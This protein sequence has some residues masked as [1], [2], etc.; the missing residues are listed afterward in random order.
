MLFGHIDNLKPEREPDF[1]IGT[2]ESTYMERWYVIPRNAEFNIY[3]HRVLRSDDDRALHDHPWASISVMCAGKLI[4]HTPEGSQLLEKGAVVFREP[5][6]THRLELIDDE[7]CETL[8]ITGPKV[9][10]WG[11]HCPKGFVPWQKF[12]ARDHT[13]SIGVGC[14]EMD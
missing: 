11:F 5:N 13:G 2:E 7:P 14:V 1:L 10:D 9:R 3:Y 12:V 4:E 6:F 8:F